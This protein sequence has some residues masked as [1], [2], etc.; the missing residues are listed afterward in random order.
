MTFEGLMLS[1][2]MN[3]DRIGFPEWQ[4]RAAVLVALLQVMNEWNRRY[5][6]KS[7]SNNAVNC[8]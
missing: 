5:G 7:V 4:G 8:L 2:P 1:E 6:P 3:G